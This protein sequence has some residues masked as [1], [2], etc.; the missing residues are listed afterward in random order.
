MCQRVVLNVLIV[1]FVVLGASSYAQDEVKFKLRNGSVY[2]ASD[3]EQPLFLLELVLEMT[4]YL[5]VKPVPEFLPWRRAQFETINSQ[6]AVIFPLTRTASRE[7]HYKWLCKLFDVPVAFITRRGGPSIN[8]YADAAKLKKIGVLLGTPQEERLNQIMA[9]TGLSLNIARLRSVSA[10]D[11][12]ANSENIVALYGP[13][14]EAMK[15]WEQKGYQAQLGTLQFGKPLQV[16]PL[17]VAAGK[18]AHTIEAKAWSQA[19][20]HVKATGRFEQLLDK[21]FSYQNSTRKQN[22]VGNIIQ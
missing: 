1:F 4:Q 12:F 5:D 17:W 10:Y 2:T 8:S 14:P 22:H 20:E 21:H 15:V 6:D 19:L 9:D 11:F 18:K 16:L 3:P 13:I 7:S